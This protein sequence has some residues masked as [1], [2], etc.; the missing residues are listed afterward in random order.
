ME[1]TCA[2]LPIATVILLTTLIECR[3]AV[4]TAFDS[5]RVAI[6]RGVDIAVASPGGP[7][8][9]LFDDRGAVLVGSPCDVSRLD[10]SM[11]IF[12]SVCVLASTKAVDVGTVL[13]DSAVDIVGGTFV[14]GSD[15][16][17]FVAVVAA[18]A[19]RGIILSVPDPA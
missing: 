1:P 3:V 8:G 15:R 2:G 5:N 18:V 12:T 10:P 14:S 19:A 9:I 6:V 17:D 7:L 4:C 13:L 16:S 11:D